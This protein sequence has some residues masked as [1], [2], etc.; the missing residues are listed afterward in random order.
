MIVERSWCLSSKIS[1]RYVLAWKLSNTLDVRFCIEGLESSLA[2]SKPEIFNTDQ[3]SQFTGKE[4][5][6]RLYDAGI[7]ISMDGRGRAFDNIFIERL[8]RSVKYEEVYL[9]AYE[10]PREAYRRLSDYFNFYNNERPHQSLGYKTP[11][12]VHF[13]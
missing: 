3:G 10:T 8:W 11:S 1:R 9:N 6:G 2:H 4:F 12:E 5:T 13:G 7:K